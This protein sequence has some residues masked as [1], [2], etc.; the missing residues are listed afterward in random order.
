MPVTY[1]IDLD[2]KVIRT[3]CTS[4][5]TFADVVG[6]FRALQQD[7]LCFGQLDVL[8]DLSTA[9]LLPES[10]QLS[11]VTGELSSIRDKVRFRSCA[12][13]TSRDAM[14]GMMRMFEAMARPYFL[15]IRVFRVGSEA[16][17]WLTSRQ[18]AGDTE[19]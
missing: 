14:F 7:P 16:E 5:L 9:D 10:S 17:A 15:A 1:S 2:R 4:P 11:A 6:H 8:L 19:Q 12:I 18:T 13:V 3:T